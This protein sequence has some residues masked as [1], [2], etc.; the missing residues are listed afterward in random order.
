MFPS[1]WE[2][3]HSVPIQ[4]T[5]MHWSKY[6]KTV[7]YPIFVYI[8][9]YVMYFYPHAFLRKASGIL[10]SPPSVHLSVCPSVTLS[11]PKLFDEIQPNLVSELITWM[12]HATAHFF[13]PRPLRPWGGAKRSNIIKFQSQNQ[14]QRFLNQTLCVFS[15]KKDIKHIKRDFH[16]TAWVRPQGSD[17]GVLWGFGDFFFEVRP[18]FVYE[19][20][21]WMA[22]ATAPLFWVP[23]P[24][25]LGEG[26]KGQIWSLNLNY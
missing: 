25:G 24:W 8:I 12:A 17:L 16:L 9:S 7:R 13:W 6:M 11:P 21:T 14:F 2:E 19:L 22:H 15:Q 18:I 5:D 1:G 4:N 20:L 23:A 10:Q 3:G 26:S